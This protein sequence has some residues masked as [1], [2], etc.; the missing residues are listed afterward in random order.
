MLPRPARRNW[1]YVRDAVHGLVTLLDARS[2]RHRACTLGASFQWSLPQWCA[3]L[4]ERYP[5][6]RWSVGGAAGERIELYADSEGALLGGE[7]LRA[8]FGPPANYDLA[9][10]FADYMQF[11]DDTGGFGMPG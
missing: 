2:P 1:H 10:A 3:L 7:R 6:F 8:E 9:A 5:A 11:L 4:A